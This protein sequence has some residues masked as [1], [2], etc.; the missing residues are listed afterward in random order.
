MY[1]AALWFMG[2]T[3]ISNFFA[4]LLMCCLPG[5]GHY[6]HPS[7]NSGMNILKATVKINGCGKR[8]K[9]KPLTMTCGDWFSCKCKSCVYSKWMYS[10]GQKYWHFCQIMHHFSQKIVAIRNA[11]V[12][13]CLFLLFALENLWGKKAK[14]AIIPHRTPKMDW[15]KW[16]ASSCKGITHF[17]HLWDINLN[18]SSPHF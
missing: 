16:L 17:Y 10:H 13:T 6:V 5:R 1:L 9:T 12:F 3:V 8:K 14:S 7:H 2:G 11:L 18:A 4:K 15:T